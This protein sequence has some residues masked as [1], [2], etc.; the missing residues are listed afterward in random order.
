M[1]TTTPLIAPWQSYKTIG[2]LTPWEAS[3]GVQM[4]YNAHL[5]LEQA[6]DF[7]F[8]SDSDSG[9]NTNPPLPT[10][11]DKNL[12][13]SHNPN[14]YKRSWYDIPNV[15]EYTGG[16]IPF[17]CG[18]VLDI[19][20]SMTGYNLQTQFPEVSTQYPNRWARS[21]Y[22]YEYLL[23]K[24]AIGEIEGKRE[25][26]NIQTEGNNHSFTPE[27]IPELG[28]FVVTKTGKDLDI[29]DAEHVVFVAEVHGLTPRQIIIIEGN[30]DDGT[31]VKHT[32]EELKNRIPDL[33]YIIY[34]H[35]D[36]PTV[37]MP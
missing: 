33:K 29:P 24:I 5:L 31:L 11:Y 7:Y 32:L 21:S 9:G 20:H 18:D 26:W 2:T 6:N 16:K 23:Q 1:P 19:T 28:D 15:F 35:A 4:A 25:V 14:S 13:I 36:L 34:G 17:V 30:P 27:N 8:W 37:G 10:N 22:G 3:V 12:P